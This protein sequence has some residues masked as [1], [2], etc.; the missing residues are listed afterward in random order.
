V[1]DGNGIVT[2]KD[3]II[4]ATPGTNTLEARIV[5]T[6]TVTFTATGAAA[7]YDVEVRFVNPPTS[8]QKAAFDSAEARW[9]RFIYGDLPAQQVTLNADACGTTHP[10]INEMVD[11]VVIYVEL[12]FIDGPSGILG[13]AGPCTS[14]SSTLH[15][16][17]GVMVFDTTDLSK[18]E[19]DGQL[20]DVILHE[21]GH[22]LGIGTQWDNRGFLQLPSDT[23]PAPIV[24]TYF[25]GPLAI[26]AFD[27]MG[28]GTYV[29]NKVP[30][31]NDNTKFGLGSLNGHWRDS[32]FVTELMTPLLNGGVPNPLTVVTAA[33]LA[34]LS[35][36]VN[37][38]ESDTYVLPSAPFASVAPAGSGNDLLLV[39]DIWRGPIFV[40]SPT[41]RIERVIRPR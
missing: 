24:D 29:G 3:W 15:T 27:D 36:V 28:G 9:E 12:K 33:S 11:D 35:Y 16:A 10:A 21:M 26:A 8:G 18:L 7:E 14:R 34:D 23:A 32:V 6:D 13:Q 40:L 30:A 5:G 1:S 2:F 37:Y 31:E 38:G 17:V 25:S 41:G 20:E 19:A 22:V 39:N 4:G